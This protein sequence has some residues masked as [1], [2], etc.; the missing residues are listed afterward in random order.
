M[1]VGLSI[2][3]LIY[4]ATTGYF[5]LRGD[6]P[7][8]SAI[9]AMI[10]VAAAV[11]F[12]ARKR[13]G[14]WLW[15]ILLGATFYRLIESASPIVASFERHTLAYAVQVAYFSLLHALLFVS[16]SVVVFSHFYAAPSIQLSASASFLAAIKFAYWILLLAGIMYF[17]QPASILLLNA[18][19]IA[20]G[21]ALVVGLPALF[22][23]IVAR[24]NVIPDR[25]LPSRIAPMHASSAK[26]GGRAGHPAAVDKVR[27]V[28]A[29]QFVGGFF[30]SIPLMILFY[31]GFGNSS[32]VNNGILLAL[33]GLMLVATLPGS[34][35]LLFI[36]FVA[37][38]GGPI[39][40]FITGVCI[41]LS[42]I[43]AHVMGMFYCRKWRP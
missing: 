8:F 33:M 38:F 6:A 37:A 9:T 26:L 36:G 2:Y 11:G 25:P 39:G 17:L 3:L 14:A 21:V 29:N 12:I 41:F 13:W 30:L 27:K 15:L 31:L 40:E 1:L 5:A 18:S 24:A 35:L 19:Y 43:N 42:V 22:G 10:S 4:A 20:F 16:G 23:Y 7:V 28:S 32:T 34:L